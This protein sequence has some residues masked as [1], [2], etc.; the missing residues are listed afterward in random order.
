M[1]I[2]KSIINKKADD[3]SLV[4]VVGRVAG[5]VALIIAILIV[6]Q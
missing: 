6:D 2:Y 3:K 5:L 4:T 1:D